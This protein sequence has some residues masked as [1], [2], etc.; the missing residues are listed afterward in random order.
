MKKRRVFIILGT[1]IGLFFLMLILLR[2]MGGSASMGQKVAVIDVTGIISKSDATIKLI[3]AYRD[4]P[5]VKAI[6]LRIDSPGGSVAPVQEIYTELEK[7]EKPIVASMAGSAASGGYYI[8]CAADTILANPGTLTGSIGVIM[9]FTRMKG[10]YDKV[11]LEHQVIKSGQ[12]KDTGSPFRTLTE[13]EQAVL[14]ATVDDVYNQF[15][16]TIAEARSNL[17]TRTEVLELADGR[18]F[19]GRQALDSKM[20]DQLGNLPDAIKIA[21]ELGGIEGSPKVLRREKKTSLFEQLVGIKQM[22]PFDEMFSLPGVT[23]RYQM[24]LGD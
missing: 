20:I 23:F 11:G 10:L 4:D 19:S 21:G 8:A 12:F 1:I 6:V 14:Q 7:I 16:D 24:N 5:S 15:V 17:L 3:H 22:P 18:I 2:S 13:E 9:Q